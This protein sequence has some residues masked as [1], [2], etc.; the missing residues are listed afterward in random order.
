ML[1]TLR[2]A[3][4]VMAAGFVL[5][6]GIAVPGAEAAGGSRT[7][8]GKH[9]ISTIDLT[10]V[11]FVP[12]DRTPLP[13]WRE[14]V[15]YFMK[16][17]DAFHRRESAGRSTLHILVHPRPLIVDRTSTKIRGGDPNQTFDNTTSK[18]RAALGW[19]G[20]H[21][22]FPI[23]LV[24]SEINWR[25]LDDFHRT[26]IV[27]GVAKHEGNMDAHGRHFP[28]A[29]S[30]G[31][32]AVYDAGNAWGIGLVSADGWRVP[33]SGSD[34]VVYHEGVGHAIGLPHPDPADDSVM[35]FAQYHFWINQTWVTASQTKALGWTDGAETRTTSQPA[36]EANDLF[37][38]FTAIQAPI[39]PKPKEPV[40]LRLTWPPGARVQEVKV[41]LQTDLYGPWITLP[42][43]AS[44]EPPR[45]PPKELAIGAFDRPTPVS[46]R[47]D[48]GLQDGQ[49][50]EIW[51]YFQVKEGK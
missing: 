15:D 10:V 14:R 45:E 30:G 11:Y 13:D 18:A 35:C 16:R 46:Y 19:P 37:T 4:L 17:I 1:D 31:A 8:D 49:T 40:R 41:R 51:G 5:G 21:Q 29:E 23:L 43:H 36:R 27:D 39:V 2:S 38:A 3:L 42:I 7:F 22:G 24:L 47:V 50:A 6:P 48:A 12:K 28:G 20:T 9:D 44:G 26:R 32:R 25:E 34:C 33:Y